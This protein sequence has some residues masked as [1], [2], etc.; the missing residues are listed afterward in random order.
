MRLKTGLADIAAKTSTSCTPRTACPRAP[1]PGCAT[2]ER[3]VQVFRT[4]HH[5]DDFSDG[6]PDRVPTQGDR[7]TGPDHRGERGVACSVAGRLWRRLRRHS[8]RRGS[9]PDSA[10]STQR[11]GMR[12]GEMPG[13]RRSLRLLVGRRHRTAQGQHDSRSRRLA[14]LG[15][16]QPPGPGAG[17]RRRPFVPGLCAVP[18]RGA[19]RPAARSACGSGRT[20]SSPA[21]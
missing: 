13:S 3:A 9:R 8:Q 10:P 7:G 4:V 17:H 21:R 6:G 20:S 1:R 18:R 12:V 19:V 11:A 5:V 14:R 16:E 15:R 2:P